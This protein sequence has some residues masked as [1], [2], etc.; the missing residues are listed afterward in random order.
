M[1]EKQINQKYRSILSFETTPET[2]QLLEKS[3][4][5][6]KLKELNKAQIDQKQFVATYSNKRWTLKVREK[7]IRTERGN[8][9]IKS[10]KLSPTVD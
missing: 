9:S 2:K 3:I 6:G 5:R 4:R 8:K 1:G 10:Y 7:A